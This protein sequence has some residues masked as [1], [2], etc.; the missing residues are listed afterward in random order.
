[1][2]ASGLSNSNSR[3]MPCTSDWRCAFASGE[4]YSMSRSRSLRNAGAAGSLFCRE[5][6]QRTEEKMRLLGPVLGRLQAELL[7]PMIERVFAV[8]NRQNKLPAAPAF[9]NDRD[10]DIEYVSPLAKAQRQSD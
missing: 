3:T 10:L 7:Q 1:M 6:V 5:V 8:L 2:P 9:L 4:T